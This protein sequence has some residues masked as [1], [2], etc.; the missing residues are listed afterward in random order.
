MKLLFQLVYVYKC[1]NTMQQS[2][3][4]GIEPHLI[5]F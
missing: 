5:F 1:V 4:C 3:W 2:R